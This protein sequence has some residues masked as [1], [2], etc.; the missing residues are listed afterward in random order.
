[1]REL[2]VPIGN[3][4]QRVSIKLNQSSY[5]ERATGESEL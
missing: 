4:C 1:M 2:E 5:R 3:S